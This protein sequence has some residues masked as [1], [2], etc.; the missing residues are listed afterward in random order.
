MC[1]SQKDTDVYSA[2]G[3]WQTTAGILSLTSGDLNGPP[4]LS[5]V[6]LN[7]CACGTY[8]DDLGPDER[9]GSLGDDTPPSDEPTGCSRDPIVLNERTGVFPITETDSETIIRISCALSRE[10]VFLPVVI[11]ATSE[12]KNYSENNEADYCQDLDGASEAV[13]LRVQVSA[14]V[15]FL[16]AAR[17][18]TQRRIRLLHMRL[19]AFGEHLKEIE[20][21]IKG[22]TGT[23][24]V[25]HD[26]HHHAN[27]NPNCGADYAIPIA[28]EDRG[29]AAGQPK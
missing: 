1:L 22:H 21:N 27:R 10:E 23:E 9:E 20:S 12:V 28:D 16:R 15:K 14:L 11:W 6:T 2:D 29:S 25:D 18:R 8:G 19:S 7:R 3:L 13:G 26:N 24:H 5:S 4:S 17:S